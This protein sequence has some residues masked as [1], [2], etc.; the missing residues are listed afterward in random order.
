[1]IWK[2]TSGI[3][4]DQDF[5]YIIKK[6]TWFVNKKLCSPAAGYS[7]NFYLHSSGDP[8][9]RL[10]FGSLFSLTHCL[11]KAEDQRVTTKEILAGGGESIF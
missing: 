9:I 5:L 7:A 1:L 10:G 11:P 4:P 8:E 2:L 6:T 3:Y